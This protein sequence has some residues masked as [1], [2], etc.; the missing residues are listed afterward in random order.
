MLYTAERQ[1]LPVAD[2]LVRSTGFDGWGEGLFRLV[3][4]GRFAQRAGHTMLV[5]EIR[6]RIR[7]LDPVY[8][9]HFEMP[10]PVDP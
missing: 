2:S 6:E 7:I 1:L 10:A 5:D 4:M 3:R 8:D 9:P